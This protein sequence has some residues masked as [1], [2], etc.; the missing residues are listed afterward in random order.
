MGDAAR[1]RAPVL[2]STRNG[3]TSAAFDLVGEALKPYAGPAETDWLKGVLV[4]ERER[5]CREGVLG[6]KAMVVERKEGD[7]VRS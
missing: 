2:F 4:S 5:W 3:F 6:A 1:L 7:V